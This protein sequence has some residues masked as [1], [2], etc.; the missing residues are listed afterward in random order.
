MRSVEVG[1][2]GP[3]DA[4]FILA[5]WKRT[6][7]EC[8]WAGCVRNDEIY[9]QV[10]LTVEGLVLRGAEFLM[11]RGPG[12]RA[13]GFVCHETLRDGL[14]CVHYLYVKD[15]YRGANVGAQLVEAVPG[16][17]PGLYTHRYRQVVEALPGPGWRHAP[18]VARRK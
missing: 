4:A 14:A 16:R 3:D 2:S 5:N 1:P 9:R 8:P 15:P 13:L 10:E 12:G 18:E 11:A 7:R 17:K 6:W